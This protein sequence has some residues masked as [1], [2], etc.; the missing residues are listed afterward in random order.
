MAGYK[1][2]HPRAYGY[3]TLK[4]PEV[5]KALAAVRPVLNALE[6]FEAVGIVAQP[7]SEVKGKSKYG[8]P[9]WKRRDLVAWCE[10]VSEGRDPDWKPDPNT[11]EIKQPTIPWEIRTKA[12][13]MLEELRAWAKPRLKHV[14]HKHTGK[15]LHAP[16][17]KASV[18]PL[19][20]Y[21]RSLPDSELYAQLEA[22]KTRNAIK[23]P[24]LEQ[25]NQPAPAAEGVT[26]AETVDA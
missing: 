13:K 17:G 8:P 1:G 21:A 11:P 16:T 2:E 15:V 14:H 20:D 12:A 19:E 10:A 25:T 6:R 4:R 5:Q 26:D 18:R 3:R 22:A 24:A 9:R 7:M 23:V